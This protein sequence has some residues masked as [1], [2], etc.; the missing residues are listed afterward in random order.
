MG[1]GSI[2]RLLARR[3]PLRPK[4]Q[5]RWLLA[6]GRCT[7]IRMTRTAIRLWLPARARRRCGRCGRLAPVY[8]F[9]SAHRLKLSRIRDAASLWSPPG[10]EL[11]ELVTANQGEDGILDLC[12]LLLARGIG[13]EAGLLSLDDAHAF[14][15]RH[16]ARA[17]SPWRRDR[18]LGRQSPSRTSGSWD[19]NRTRG[20]PRAT[21]WASSSR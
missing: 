13:I 6:R 8:L 19:T 18:L 11:P 12:D 2:R 4:P 10:T 17:N 14:V 3:R 21:R 1:I 15:S 16:W 7:C 5:R 9:H 20:H